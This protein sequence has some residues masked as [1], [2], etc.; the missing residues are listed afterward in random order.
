MSLRGMTL[1]RAVQPLLLAA[2]DDE[3]MMRLPPVLSDKEAL[4][5]THAV[6]LPI[7]LTPSSS[8]R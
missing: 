1:P 5:I 6:L 8:G 2:V 4:I 7:D 3:R